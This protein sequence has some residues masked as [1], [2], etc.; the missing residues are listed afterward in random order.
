MRGLA[1]KI[2]DLGAE[3]TL[4]G[5]GTPEQGRAF[6]ERTESPFNVLVDPQLVGY[7]AAELKQK[8]YGGFRTT[9]LLRL[10]KARLAGFRS[11]GI[12]GNPHQ[13]GG[14]FVIT[15]D[16]ELAYSYISKTLDDR[17][18]PRTLL[19]ALAKLQAETPAS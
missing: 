10:I 15:S 16:N 6:A 17:G 7:H 9:T 12:Q 4:I 2:R 18:D 3:L 13:L 11:P 8:L 14:A 19:E 5:T 1:Q